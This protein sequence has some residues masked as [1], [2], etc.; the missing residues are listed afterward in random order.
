MEPNE[1]QLRQECWIKRFY[2]FGTAR[3]FE[4]RAQNINRK[5]QIITFLGLAAP[6]TV[7]AFVTAFSVESELL[8]YVLIPIAGLVIL[9]QSIMSLWSLV[10][11]W[12]E[13]YSYSI[14]ATKSNTRLTVDFEILAKSNIKKNQ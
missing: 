9:I 13:N 2:S 8:K 6:L 5:R 12:D 7:G 1:E 11:K 3:I 10:A 4:R 14:A